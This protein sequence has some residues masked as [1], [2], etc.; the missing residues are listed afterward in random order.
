MAVV[1][2]SS[3]LIDHLRTLGKGKSSKFTE[4]QQKETDLVFSLITVGELFSGQ[5]AVVKEKEIKALLS[6]GKI[7][8]LNYE[9]MHT[10]GFIRG[11]TGIDL[12]DAVIAATCLRLNLPLATLNTKDFSK[13]LG[14]KIY[15]W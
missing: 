2:D 3:V 10:A 8:D 12:E 4:I 11:K 1:I 13:V 15:N 7:A 5:S 6:L 9:L 14:V